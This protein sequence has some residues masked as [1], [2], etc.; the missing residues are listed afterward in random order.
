MQTWSIYFDTLKENY[1]SI[2]EKEKKIMIKKN[3]FI[4]LVDVV[5]NKKQHTYIYACFLNCT[6]RLQPCVYCVPRGLLFVKPISYRIMR[7]L[8][9][10]IFCPTIIHT[11]IWTKVSQVSLAQHS[12]RSN[13]DFLFHISCMV[14]MGGLL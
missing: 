14:V 10:H 9:K 13:A 2:V 8:L 6:V 3:H 4:D 5:Q 7:N 1:D 12:Y 11:L